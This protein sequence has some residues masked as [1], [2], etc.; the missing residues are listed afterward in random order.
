M[1][2]NAVAVQCDAWYVSST[3][4]LNKIGP[5]TE[6]CSTL[7]LAVRSDEQLVSICTK[8]CLALSN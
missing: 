7:Y 2:Y 4:W 6:P 1:R 8:C 3:H 5:S